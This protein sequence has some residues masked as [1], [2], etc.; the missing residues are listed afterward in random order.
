MD[1]SQDTFLQV[2]KSLY[3]YEA[4]S[5]E[6]TWI[7]GIAKHIWLDH[8]RKKKVEVEYDDS[9]GQKENTKSLGYDMESVLQKLKQVNE[10]QYELVQYRLQGYSHSE[11]AGFMQCSEA[12]VR[13]LFH[14]CKK[15]MKEEIERSEQNESSLS[16]H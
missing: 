10:K 5:S 4:K 8:L 14:R 12:S 16:D 13:V 6:R 15:W 11:I 9:V 1:L 2:M 7:M 3:R